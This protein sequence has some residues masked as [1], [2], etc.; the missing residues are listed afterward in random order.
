MRST[1]HP[2][3]RRPLRRPVGALLAAGLLLA[4]TACSAAPDPSEAADPGTQGTR[5]VEAG[6][7]VPDLRVEV[8]ADG[9]DHPWDVKPIG[10][11]RLLLTQRDRAT[12]SLWEDGEV[13]TLD[14]PSEDV[15]VSG[16]TGLLGLE[17]DPDVRRNGRF[18]TCQGATNQGGGHDVRVMAWQLS[19]DLRSV[20]RRGVLLKG[21]PAT[22][23]RHGGCR[24]LVARDG[25]LLVGTGDAAVGSHPRDLTSLGGKVLRLDRTTGKPWP[26]NP[27]VDAD[28]KRQRYVFTY[29][30]RNVQGLAQRADGSLWSVE[31]GSFRDDEVNRLV[32]GGDHGWHPV[33]GYDESVPMTDQSLPGRQREAAWRSGDPT[34]APGGATFVVGK[35]WG[36]LRGTLAMAV[37]KDQRV[38]FLK[39]DASGRLKNVR[40]PDELREHG[41]IRQV[42]RAPGNDLL[43]LTDN[44]D[45]RDV[46]LRVSPR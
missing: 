18:W 30:H 22:S 23:G 39:F 28:N 21:L 6:R 14:F 24:L 31:H 11:G 29:G 4:S 34:I 15:W 12:V 5:P 45:G 37:L 38:Q 9:L 10:G 20:E 2:V 44:G 42:V 40:I 13:R 27:F 33:P 25:S 1:R 3:L 8:L 43:V 19:D 26:G 17:V 46:M 41:R 32:K 35:K 16:E 7:A 36:G